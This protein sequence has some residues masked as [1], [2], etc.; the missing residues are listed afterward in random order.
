MAFS[1]RKWHDACSTAVVMSRKPDSRLSTHWIVVMQRSFQSMVEVA[2]RPVSRFQKPPVMVVHFSRSTDM[3]LSRVSISSRD[4]HFTSNPLSVFGLMALTHT[5]AV[6]I[7]PSAP[8]ETDQLRNV[9]RRTM[10]GLSKARCVF[11]AAVVSRHFTHQVLHFDKWS[12]R[13]WRRL[14]RV[15]N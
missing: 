3:I 8:V 2:W 4:A 5:L 15:L 7:A 13:G 6:A 9:S 1:G 10:S 11:C 12:S 14:W